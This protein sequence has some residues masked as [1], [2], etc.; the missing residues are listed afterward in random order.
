L[1]PTEHH[2]EVELGELALDVGE[3]LLELRLD[4][5]GT[6]L[7]TELAVDLDLLEGLLDAPHGIDDAARELLLADQ[8]L[9]LLGVVPETR[10]ELEF[11]DLRQPLGVAGV[12]KDSP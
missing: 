6:E 9:A 4:L 10:L 11:L 1:R 12:V 8:A 5:A 3:E 7:L 2:A